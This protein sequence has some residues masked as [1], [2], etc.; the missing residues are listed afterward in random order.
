MKQ[1][2]LIIALLAAAF[3]LVAGTQTAN[4]QLSRLHFGGYRITRISPVSFRSVR[5]T[6]EFQ[7]QND[8]V[9]FTMSNI[10]G[11]VYKKGKAFVRGD[12]SP[13]SIPSGSSTV[14][15]NGTASLC[16]GITLWDVLQCIAF[17]A[18]DY[19]IDVSMTIITT[20]GD[21]REVAKSGLSVAALLNNVMRR[22]GK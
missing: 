2:R 5:G 21:R 16:E 3:L 8:T 18:E 9:G 1:S 4:A 22:K 11:T 14:A 7:I 13:V 19:S 15:V 20:K 6:A 10:S 12:A 17:K